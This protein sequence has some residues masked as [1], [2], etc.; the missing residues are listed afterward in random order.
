MSKFITRCHEHL[1]F[2]TIFFQLPLF[3]CPQL[4]FEHTLQFIFLSERLSPQHGFIQFPYNTHPKQTSKIK[5]YRKNFSLLFFAVL[6]VDAPR[7][8]SKFNFI[9]FSCSLRKAVK[10][11]TIYLFS[12]TTQKKFVC[13]F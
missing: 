13:Y 12:T 2:N 11:V 10:T 9:A 3:C 6:L 5:I 8:K 1:S 7:D 4:I